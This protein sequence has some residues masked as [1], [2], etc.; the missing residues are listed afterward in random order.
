MENNVL[1]YNKIWLDG[2]SVLMKLDNKIVNKIWNDAD[3][4]FK[5]RIS[6][7]ERTT[8]KEIGEQ[9]FKDIIF[10]L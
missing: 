2:F 3:H 4:F 9:D 1:D 6:L 7:C 5:V 10:F 8:E